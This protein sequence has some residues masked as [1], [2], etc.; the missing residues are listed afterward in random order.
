[1]RIDIEIKNKL[2]N[3]FKFFYWRVKLK[4]KIN[5]TKGQK[6]SKE[7]GSNWKKIYITNCVWIVK[8]ETN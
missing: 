4:R 8:I 2:E 6:K 5:L 3:N 1:M 7:W